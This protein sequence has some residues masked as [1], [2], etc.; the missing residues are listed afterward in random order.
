MGV[1]RSNAKMSMQISLSALNVRSALS[2]ARN[3]FRAEGLLDIV[4]RVVLS[5]SR[6]CPGDGYHL[7]FARKVWVRVG[8]RLGGYCFPE[9]CEGLYEFLRVIECGNLP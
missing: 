7:P 5:F 4:I 2:V 9:L 8:V 6:T 3:A 1:L